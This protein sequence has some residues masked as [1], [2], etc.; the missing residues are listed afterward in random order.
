MSVKEAIQHVLEMEKG[1]GSAR[2]S[3]HIEIDHSEIG[4]ECRKIFEIQKKS[5]LCFSGMS[6]RDAILNANIEYKVKDDS[7]IFKID[8]DQI[9]NK[10]RKI[11]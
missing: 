10:F 8:L 5:G 4:I 11:V 6:L 2:I 3:C 7:N 1:E 9:D